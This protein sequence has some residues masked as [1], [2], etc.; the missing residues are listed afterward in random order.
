MTTNETQGNTDQIVARA[1]ELATQAVSLGVW[2]NDTGLLFVEEAKN[3]LI[4]DEQMVY[5]EKALENSSAN[6]G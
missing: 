5:W 2:S 4:D 1:I 3:G 6:K